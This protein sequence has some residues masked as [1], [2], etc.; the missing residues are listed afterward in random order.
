MKIVML[1]SA[2]VLIIAPSLARAAAK[3]SS[4]QLF[5]KEQGGGIINLPLTDHTRNDGKTD[6]Q[7]YAKISVGT[8]PQEL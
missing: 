8:P 2:A 5:R 7:W 1:L 3:P 6:L 4:S